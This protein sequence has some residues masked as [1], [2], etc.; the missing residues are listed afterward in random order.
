MKKLFTK[1]KHP[2]IT[3]WLV[4]LVSFGLS[5]FLVYSRYQI[6][7]D[8]DKHLINF[9]LNQ[10][11]DRLDQT[12]LYNLSAARSMA[13]M[14]EEF[15]EPEMFDS[16]ASQIYNSNKSL[17]GLILTKGTNITNIFPHT[18]NQREI[19]NNIIRITNK[20]NESKKVI[21]FQDSFILG[22]LN[23]DHK[24]KFIIGGHPIFRNNEKEGYAIVI[25]KFNTI[26]RSLNIDTS[27]FQFQLNK[28][29]DDSR[30]E[31]N[32]YPENSEFATKNAAF[33]TLHDGG[34]KL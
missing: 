20:L 10:S 7:K 28:V 32:I 25:V 3:A 11:K 8:D 2:V 33:I 13:F 26:V 27:K 22:N 29:I 24:E 16:V 18:L 5:L 1:I 4:F 6:E 12:F 19:E 23:S 14:I 17:D 34:W 15:G 21:V 30:N 9:H 31:I